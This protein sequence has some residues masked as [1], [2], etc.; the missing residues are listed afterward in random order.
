MMLREEG[1]GAGFPDGAPLF[2]H[3]LLYM[4]YCILLKGKQEK[5]V[6]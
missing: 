2:L 1:K 3:S 6:I 4:N 5:T